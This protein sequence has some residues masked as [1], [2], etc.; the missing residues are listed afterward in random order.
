MRECVCSFCAHC[1]YR[2]GQEECELGKSQFGY[3]KTTDDCEDFKSIENNED[4]D[5][6]VKDPPIYIDCPMCGSDAYWT[7]TC[8]ECQNEDCGWYGNITT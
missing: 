2:C 5:D 3:A 8:Y 6:N 1:G 7:G 4:E